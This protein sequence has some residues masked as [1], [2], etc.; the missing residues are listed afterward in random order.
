MKVLLIDPWGI[1]NLKYYDSGFINGMNNHVELD[2]LANVYYSGT[3][4]NGKFFPVFF[5]YS[6]HMNRGLLRSIV[7]GI[8][9]ILG[10]KRVINVAKSKKYD[11]IHIQ[12]LLN[13]NVD[14]YFL[15]KLQK[16][17]NKLVLTA[18]NVIPHENGSVYIN[19]LKQIYSYFTDILVHGNS[20]KKEFERFFPQYIEKVHI[21]HHGEYEKHNTEWHMEDTDEFIRIEEASNKYSKILIMFGLHF[22]N[23]GTDRLVKI[24]KNE[25]LKED[26]LLLILGKVADEYDEF[27]CEIKS[28][29]EEDNIYIIDR[30]VEDNLLNFA[31]SKSDCILLPYRHASMSGVIYSASEYSK[32]VLCTDVGSLPEYLEPGID[33]FVC[34]EDDQDLALELHRILAVP[35]LQLKTMGEK[36]NYNIHRNYSWHRITKDLVDNVYSGF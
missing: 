25:F 21:Q 27:K 6:E 24:W 1:N 15:R 32:T 12:W 5:K 23:K 35:S 31:V 17:S 7:R 34:K 3:M 33:S 14:I 20:I 30:F 16:F 18:H 22:Y 26:A 10:W 9:Y 11:V 29:R 8:E 13:Y 36:L 2:F 4:P 19:Q 28:L